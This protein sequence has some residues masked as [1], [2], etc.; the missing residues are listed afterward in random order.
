MV[1]VPSHSARGSVIRSRPADGSSPAPVAGHHRGSAAG[2]VAGPSAGRGVDGVGLGRN[3]GEGERPADDRQQHAEDEPAEVGR[4]ERDDA[5]HDPGNA[6]EHPVGRVDPE[7]DAR[8][9]QQDADQHAEH[10][11]DA[12]VDHQL[13]LALDEHAGQRQRQQLQAG[14]HQQQAAPERTAAPPAPPGGARRLAALAA[15]RPGRR[16]GRRPGRRRG[17]RRRRGEAGG[18]RVRLRGGTRVVSRHAVSSPRRSRGGG[19]AG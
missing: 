15:V 7:H 8:R 19:P 6:V 3:P 2:V 17:F 9:D 10:A 4:G 13:D 12:D 1:A 16:R 11:A 18:I 5:E 14:Q